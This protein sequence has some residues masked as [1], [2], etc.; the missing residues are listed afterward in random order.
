MTG[1]EKCRRALLHQ[2]QKERDDLLATIMETL[3]ADE[4]V[5]AAWLA[6]SLGRGDADALSDLDLWV[7]VE[8][9]AIASIAAD[10]RDFVASIAEPCLVIEEPRNASRGGAYLFTHF[11]GDTGAHQVDWYWQAASHATRPITTQLLFEQWPI[12]TRQPPGKLAPAELRARLEEQVVLFWATVMLAVKAVARGKHR[13]VHRSIESLDQLQRTLR[14]LL[15]HSAPPDFDDLRHSPLPDVLPISAEEQLQFLDAAI[16]TVLAT[17]PELRQHGVVPP[18]ESKRQ[19]HRWLDF[20][21]SL[22]AS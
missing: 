4:R 12:P 3:R 7:I 20:V 8:N 19:V 1:A 10:P 5:V 16:A 18:V 11:P 21:R 9:D 13:S 2:R 6:G 17:E 22:V 15:D 14:W